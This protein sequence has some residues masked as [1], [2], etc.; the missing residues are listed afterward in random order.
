MDT[1]FAPAGRTDNTRLK[2]Q[3]DR[4]CHNQIMDALLQTAA[5]LLVILN[6]DRQIVA[7]NHSFLDFLGVKN[8]DE[9][10][11]FRVGETL[12]CTHAFDEPSGCGTTEACLSCGAAIA[13][14]SAIV[15]N[16]PDEKIC[17]LLS[18]KDGMLSNMCLLIKAQPIRLDNDRWILFYAQDITRQRFWHNLERVFFH[19]INNILTALS[20]NAQL[21]EY[22]YPQSPETQSV[23]AGIDRLIQE[24]NIQ[25][26]LCLDRQETFSVQ[27]DPVTMGTIRQEIGMFLTGHRSAEDK[28]IKEVWPDDELIIKTDPL[29]VSRVIGNMLINALEA[30]APGDTVKLTVSTSERDLFWDIWNPDYIPQH[31]QTRIFQKH[32]TTKDEPSR[33]LGTFS[34]KLFGEQYLG[35]RVTF[36]SSEMEGTVFTLCLPDCLE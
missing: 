7:V 34:M 20:G 29:L 21:L 1:Y 5:G 36:T 28:M 11:G 32:F 31:I 30:S 19:D 23:R 35:G 8:I 9:I 14:M 12:H 27:R 13:M 25:K 18:R 16:R 24:V 26:T 15:H 2:D 22:Q 17:A 33:G 6:E 10:L 4:V 3:I